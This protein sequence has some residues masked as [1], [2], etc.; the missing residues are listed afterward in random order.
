[1]PQIRVGAKIRA[2]TAP[3]VLLVVG[4]L[5]AGS[6][7]G[8]ETEPRP[9]S[10]NRTGAGGTA[11][12]TPPAP[13]PR[14]SASPSPSPSP[15]SYPSQGNGQFRIAAGTGRVM[16]RSGTLMRFQV[17]VEHGIS[18]LPP[19]GF[20]R[21]V[22]SILGDPRGWT[23]GGDWRLQRVGPG[24]P[25][26]FTVYLSTPVTRDQ[27]CGAV[28]DRYTSCRNGDDVVIN[29]SRWVHGVPYYRSLT[30]YREYAISHEVG[31]RLGHGHELCPGKGRPA[32]T[33]QQQTLGMHGCTPWPWPYRN[34]RRYAGPE[35]EYPLI[36]PTDPARYYR[37]D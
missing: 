21:D 6:V 19:A 5:L 1:M 17:A 27:L 18:N 3:A 22:V 24:A 30:Q 29:V 10:A 11:P 7:S 15:V 2:L 23:A 14:H 4:V 31:H 37:H 26:D 35:G 8:C 12:H 36:V 25:H 32:P 16:G 13:N 33:M 20:A 34:D 28:F 9:A